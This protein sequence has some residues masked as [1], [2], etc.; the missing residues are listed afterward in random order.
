MGEEKQVRPEIKVKE[1]FYSLQGEGA[2]TGV[3]SVFVRFSDCNLNCS[4]CDTKHED[5][6]LMTI[7]E[8]IEN[9][10]RYPQAEWI[11]LTGGEPTLQ[12][13]YEIIALIKK[14][15]NKKIAIET[16]GTSPVPA[17]ID[18]VTVSP[19]VSVIIRNA[20][21]DEKTEADEIKVVDTGQILESYFCNEWRKETTQFFLQPCW[22]K[23]EA[24]FKANTLRTVNR[25]LAD[26]R[27]RLS[28]QVHRYLGI[29]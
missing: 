6:R 4:F 2:H 10:N 21:D 15:T 26:P 29:E 7:D 1:I 9:V 23:D 20:R 11:I 8:V 5:G 14:G 28:A 13:T 25:V 12:L 17:N 22:V 3:P 27:W 24:E 19:K 18:W 16:N